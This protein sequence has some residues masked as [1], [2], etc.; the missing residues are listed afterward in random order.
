MEDVVGINGAMNMLDS[1]SC[2]GGSEVS[3]EGRKEKDG[4][5]YVKGESDGGGDEDGMDE[6]KSD[7][8]GLG[9]NVGAYVVGG[10]VGASPFEPLG[11]TV[12]RGVLGLGGG[13]SGFT[14]RVGIGVSVCF[15]GPGLGGSGQIR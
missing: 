1:L 5:M 14:N 8:D 6:G 7:D 2:S 9:E 12:G 3:N 11:S 15:T 10:C 4:R 13:V